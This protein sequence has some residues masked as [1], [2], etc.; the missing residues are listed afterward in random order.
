VRR[1]IALKETVQ[2][3]CTLLIQIHSLVRYRSSQFGPN[4]SLQTTAICTCVGG[5]GIE[6]A[7]A[8][9]AAEQSAGKPADKNLRHLLITDAPSVRAALTQ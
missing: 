9:A 1:L 4:Y 8:V 6:A 5:R 2:S 3:L 7:A